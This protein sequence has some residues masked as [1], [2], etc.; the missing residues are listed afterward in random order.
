[1]D[2]HN[3]SGRFG[4]ILTRYFN[5]RIA[6]RLHCFPF[7]SKSASKLIRRGM[8][9]YHAPDTIYFPWR[10]VEPQ[11]NVRFSRQATRVVREGQHVFLPDGSQ[12]KTY[13]TPLKHF[14]LNKALLFVVYLF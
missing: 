7:F 6:L 2:T 9:C 11:H 8:V 14:L 5:K 12:L 10:L 13:L 4:N 1:M 3:D